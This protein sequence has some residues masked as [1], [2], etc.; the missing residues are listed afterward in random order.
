MLPRH[1]RIEGGSFLTDVGPPDPASR[2]TIWSGVHESAERELVRSHIVAGLPVVELGAGIGVVSYAAWKAS[3]KSQ[4]VLVEANPRVA[5]VLMAN[6]ARN[7][8]D[9][10][11]EQAAIA[12]G[13][14]TVEFEADDRWWVAGA[15]AGGSESGGRIEVEAVTLTDV[16]DRHLGSDADFQLITD[17]EGGEWEI[18]DAEADLLRSRVKCIVAELH[19]E[20]ATVEEVRARSREALQPLGFEEVG[21]RGPVAAY[22]R[23]IS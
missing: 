1:A 11:V 14:K 22:R 16:V 13:A 5:R 15:V 9:A 12:Y 7:R 10:L 19:G 6:M 23:R 8:V 18:F 17:I 21:G 20:T 2:I 3:A 4:V